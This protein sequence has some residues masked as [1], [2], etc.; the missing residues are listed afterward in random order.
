MSFWIQFSCYFFRSECKNNGLIWHQ[1]TFWLDEMIMTAGR[2]SLSLAWC[3]P[4]GVLRRWKGGGVRLREVICLLATAEVVL[5]DYLSVFAPRRRLLPSACLPLLPPP[6]LCSQKCSC[7]T[8]RKHVESALRTSETSQTPTG[9]EA[10]L[11]CLPLCGDVSL[12]DCRSWLMIWAISLKVGL[13]VGSRFQQ[14]V[15]SSYLSRQMMLDAN[16]CI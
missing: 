2:C 6:P 4:H 7:T 14:S 1:K 13:S 8:V 16:K 10:C 15:I 12:V 11:T 5:V 9:T 3:H